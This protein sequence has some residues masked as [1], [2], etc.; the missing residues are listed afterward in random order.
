MQCLPFSKHFQFFRRDVIQLNTSYYI[1]G[2]LLVAHTVVGLKKQLLGETELPE[3][4]Q[5]RCVYHLWILCRS[6]RLPS[7]GKE[8]HSEAE[9]AKN[10]SSSDVERRNDMHRY[11]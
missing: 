4:M 2:N 5:S 10:T 3:E 9:A 1:Y 6:Q 11:M 7:K 8:W